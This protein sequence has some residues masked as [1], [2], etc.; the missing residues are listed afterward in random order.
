MI[1]AAIHGR[2]IVKFELAEEVLRSF[3]EVRF[4]ARGVSML[5][6]IFPGDQLVVRREPIEDAHAGDV[7]LFRR[8]GRLFAHRV[9]A[10]TCG[11]PITR[12]DALEQ[13]DTPI[14]A[15]EWLGRVSEVIRSG[16]SLEFGV[17]CSISTTFLR[18][19]VRRS[20]L[21][22]KW[23]LR[24]RL[25]RERIARFAQFVRPTAIVEERT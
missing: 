6:A 9:V 5:P 18:W 2:E 8:E 3:G 1:E 16:K 13:S 11:T 10:G 24:F 15:D 23:L 14:T 12:G 25:I 17:D 7:V 4:T 22:V 20:D 19:A 21:A